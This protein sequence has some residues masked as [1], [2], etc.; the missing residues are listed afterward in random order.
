MIF[1]Y[2]WKIK[3]FKT[4]CWFVVLFL[5]FLYVYF[6]PKKMLNEYMANRNIMYNFSG[7]H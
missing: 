1:K 2:H 3:Q 4:D 5:H 6:F 7:Y